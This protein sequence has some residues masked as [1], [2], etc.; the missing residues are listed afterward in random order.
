MGIRASYWV[1]GGILTVL[2]LAIGKV[3]LGFLAGVALAIGAV[4]LKVGLV[5]LALFVIWL[6]FRKARG[7]GDE[8]R[9]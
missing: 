7:G 2:G 9:A 6:M 4:L 8:A 3:V 1:T 5:V